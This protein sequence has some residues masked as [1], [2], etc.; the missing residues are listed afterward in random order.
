MG[1]YVGQAYAELFPNKLKGFISIDSAPLQRKYVTGIEL[2]LLKKMEPVYRYYP[3]KSLLKTGTNGVATSEY[4]RKLMHDIMM[5]YDG[6]QKRYAKIAGHG[7]KYWQK[8][9]KLIFHTG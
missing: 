1:G 3:W 7:F 8:Q 2:W 4:G 9:W 6:D 5:I